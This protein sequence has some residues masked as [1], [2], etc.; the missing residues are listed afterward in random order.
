MTE[1]TVALT[2]TQQKAVTIK[3]FI[4]KPGIV[5]QLEAALPRFLNADRFLRTIYSAMLQNPKL[6]DC[7]QE[8][9]LSSMVQAAQLG[10]EPVLGK[11]ALIPYGKEMQFQPM[12]RGLIDLAMRSDKIDKITAHTVYDKDNF[13]IEYGTDE[14]LTH[15]PFLDGD[16]GNIRGSY[17]VWYYKDGGTTHS[18][19]SISDIQKIRDRS[20]AWKAFL[21]YKKTCPWNTD[22]SEMCKKTV[23]KRHSKLQPCSVE[24][25][26][27]VEYDNALEMGR[28]IISHAK[29][30]PPTKAEL[31]TDKIKKKPEY[32]VQGPA[33]DLSDKLDEG[34]KGIE[35]YQ[36][37]K[38][39]KQTKG[40][41]EAVKSTSDRTQAEIEEGR[42][43]LD[44]HLMGGTKPTVDP[45]T[46][47]D[48]KE[49]LT[50]GATADNTLEQDEPQGVLP[51]GTDAMAW[52][53]TCKP[54]SSVSNAK[55]VIEVAKEIKD[56]I[57]ALTDVNLQGKL[58]NKKHQATAFLAEI[59]NRK[60]QIAEV[61][62]DAGVLDEDKIP[63]FEQNHE[64]DTANGRLKFLAAMKKYMD[65]DWDKYDKV[66]K[67]NDIHGMNDTKPGDEAVVLG[68]MAQAFGD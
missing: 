3:D 58:R 51:V 53:T 50:I 68:F 20:S 10:L 19:M 47:E 61:P 36:N 55:T 64:P 18:Y 5:S 28:S 31:L 54:R 35:G 37:L 15:K 32:K 34:D 26:K 1:R 60:K 43:E 33:Q 8:S 13:A 46:G 11:A 49:E 48:L 57:D 21:Q 27:A 4:H 16:R 6:L 62:L 25:E 45:L 56:A 63:A 39:D 14:K 9:L 44:E 30:I 22:E 7:T 12:F 52:M 40:Y 29:D 41:M 59:E 2:T 65:K 23:I 67:K 38:G 24:F 17:T 42:K 66:L